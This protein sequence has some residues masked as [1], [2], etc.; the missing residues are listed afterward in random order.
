MTCHLLP[1]GSTG[2]LEA[3]EGNWGGS[4][5]CRNH[6]GVL[7]CGSLSLNLLIFPAKRL[8]MRLSKMPC[9][10]RPPQPLLAFNETGVPNSPGQYSNPTVSLFVQVPLVQKGQGSSLLS[11]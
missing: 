5:S 9:D 2:S 4:R 6:V 3:D 8:G 1:A 7:E 10:V 11:G